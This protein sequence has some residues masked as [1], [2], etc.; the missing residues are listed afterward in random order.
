MKKVILMLSL[1]VLVAGSS[2]AQQ[3]PQKERNN[4]TEQRDGKDKRERKSPEERAA[5]RTAKMSEELGLNKSQ[6]K[7]LQALHLKQA[8]ELKE[9]RAQ[10]K[11]TGKRNKNQNREEMKAS[12]EKMQASREKWDAELK[13]ILTKKQYAQYQE[14]REEMRAQH[15]ERNRDGYKDRTNRHHSQRS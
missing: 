11:H 7:K 13:D 15:K 1:G 6:T 10:Y 2:I 8:N 3:A 4:R 5:L 12:R 14:Q 9:M